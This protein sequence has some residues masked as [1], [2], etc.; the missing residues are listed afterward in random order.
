MTSSPARA[1]PT[2]RACEAKE[3][4]DYRRKLS[5]PYMD[6]LRFAPSQDTVHPDV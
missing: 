6:K 4:A 2:S 5:T 3:F 1:R